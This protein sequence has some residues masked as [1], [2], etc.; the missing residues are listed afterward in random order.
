MTFLGIT[1][2]YAPPEILKKEEHINLFKADI[3]AFGLICCLIINGIDDKQFTDM[4]VGLSGNFAVK[5][6]YNLM[7]EKI[8]EAMTK[9]NKLPVKI[10][11]TIKLMIAYEPNER[12][13]IEGVEIGFGM[14]IPVLKM[15]APPLS[16][17]V[18]VL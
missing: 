12:L 6:V 5:E 13:N 10:I 14:E 9:K 3:F 8:L 18:M 2:T 17:V 1:I 7:L 16:E 4:M 11:D 15:T